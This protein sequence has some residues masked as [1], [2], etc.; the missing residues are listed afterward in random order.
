MY[1]VCTIRV[2]LHCLYL[3]WIPC[4]MPG[5][6]NTMR[7]CKSKCDKCRKMSNE[8]CRLQK[9]IHVEE[10][11]HHNIQTPTGDKTCKCD[12]CIK[13]FSNASNQQR[14]GCIHTGENRKICGKAFSQT[15]YL[16]TH[17]RTQTGDKLYKRR[18]EILSGSMMVC[19]A[20]ILR[21][22]ITTC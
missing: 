1:S 2:N 6:W 13:T 10:E 17:V 11:N 22:K 14:H 5:M 15:Y 21:P 8:L 7:R 12:I 4:Y 3:Y 19:Q 9:T 16:K 18:H 20:A